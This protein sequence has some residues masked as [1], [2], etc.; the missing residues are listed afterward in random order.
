MMPC[1]FGFCAYVLVL[2]LSLVL[3]GLAVS[4]P[5]FEP[6]ILGVLAF[7][8]DQLSIRWDWVT[9]NCGSGLAL[10]HTWKPEGSLYS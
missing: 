7:L 3:V 5:A 4:C 2:V 9:E 1:S 8:R 10:G 6:V